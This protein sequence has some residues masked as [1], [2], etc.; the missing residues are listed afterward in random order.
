MESVERNTIT[1]TYTQAS[2][3]LDDV[4]GMYN[5]MVDTGEIIADIDQKEVISHLHNLNNC[6]KYHSG[7]KTN[8]EKRGF[9]DWFS[10]SSTK[11]APK[12]N[13]IY[14]YGGVGR[15]K[16]MLMD[17][18]FDC[19]S[20]T[21][22]RRVHFHAFML[23]IHQRI[24][25]LRHT[26]EKGDIIALIAAHVAETATLLCFDELQVTDIA[27]AMILDRLF[28]ALFEKGVVIVAT[29][30]RPPDDL[31]KDGLQR[32]RFLPCI[33]RL[34][35]NMNILSLDGETDYRLQHLRSLETIYYT[36]LNKGAQPFINQTFSSLTHHAPPTTG[37]L[38]TQGRTITVKK[39]YGCV[40]QFSFSD[41]CAV[42]L[43]AADYIE[44]A[45]EFTT[46]LIS[47]IPKMGPDSRNEAKRFATLID[48]FYEH[49]TKLICTAEAE[50]S[51]LYTK[52]DYA[53][54]F[55]RTASRLI[56]MQTEHYLK[57]G[58]LYD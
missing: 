2:D 33:D 27:D 48:T 34:K 20:F 19:T 22:K 6:L 11:T 3:Y 58:I 55:E 29:S 26:G 46:V 18:F 17:S 13:G 35:S 44:I 8:I 31:Y 47:D 25:Q 16:S 5:A 49:K 45:R 42:P 41:L 23:E 54:E 10:K 50:P 51:Q 40:A 24:H 56:E 37:Q 12:I 32:I 9:F 57:E 39:M 52:G 36:P 38:L 28:E 21:P 15:G 1:K 43:G 4:K 53:F 14:L 30:N 7:S